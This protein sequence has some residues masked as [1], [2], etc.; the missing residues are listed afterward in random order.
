[1]VAAFEETGLAQAEFCHSRGLNL[2]T[3]RHWLYRLRREQNK[4]PK[5]RGSKL[6]EL[7]PAAEQSESATC[8]LRVRGGE[9]RFS[10]CPDA[11]WLS[12]LLRAVDD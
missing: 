2:G 12:T 3:F 5:R 8:V 7:V 11:E 6:I 4:M 10:H 1:M 9:L